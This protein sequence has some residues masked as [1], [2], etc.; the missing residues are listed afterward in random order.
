MFTTNIG[1][2]LPGNPKTAV[3]QGNRCFKGCGRL[4]DYIF[5]LK[6]YLL[7]PWYLPL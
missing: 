4:N 5:F 2:K 7:L 3:E 6:L 1:I